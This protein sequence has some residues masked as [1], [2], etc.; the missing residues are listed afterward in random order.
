MTGI[1]RLRKE[2]DRFLMIDDTVY[3]LGDSLKNLGH[4]MTTVLKT[5]FTVEE[6]LGKL[7]E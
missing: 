3:I 7:K 2:H 1:Q 4:S 6:I 5:S